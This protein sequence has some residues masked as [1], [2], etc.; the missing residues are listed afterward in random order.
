MQMDTLE[1]IA[2]QLGVSLSTVSRALA[3]KKGVSAAKRQR[4]VQLSQQLG[5]EP[6]QSASSLR[7]GTA[8]GVTVFASIR[9]T[10]VVHRRNH[11]LIT[12][13]KQAFGS[14][15]MVIVNEEE[16]INRLLRQTFAQGTRALFFGGFTP[17]LDESTLHWAKEN[18]LILCG[19]DSDIPGFDTI[20][21]NRSI[22]TYQAARLFLLS[23]RKNIRYICASTLDAPDSRLQGIIQAYQ[24]LNNEL[25]SRCLVSLLGASYSIGY[26]L[27]KELLSQG[28]VDAVFGYNDQVTI[29]IYKALCDQ[30]IRIP[31]DIALIGFDNLDV[32]E[33]LSVPLTSV[34]QPMQESVDAA[35]QLIQ[36]RIENPHL[37]CKTITLP[38]R[39][40]ARD[41]AP[42]G[43]HSLR[44]EIF[45]VPGEF[46]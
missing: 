17:E 44:E 18:Q 14:V 12:E 25:D 7:S 42:I 9:A 10:E 1:E 45:S 6:N 16:N 19:V 38:T 31:A 13:A 5:I 34:A 22:G 27:G 2:K 26:R 15:R 32:G 21:I 28:A 39:L 36:W 30:G 24:S 4:I 29:G 23:G 41:S 40:I 43:D 46:Q 3:G 8:Q 33:Y 37:P 35:I 11:L 20:R